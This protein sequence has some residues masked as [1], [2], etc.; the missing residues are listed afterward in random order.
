MKLT[1]AILFLLAF[2]A[3]LPAQSE[4]GGSVL[5]RLEAETAEL[6]AQA[7]AAVVSVGIWG[8]DSKRPLLR[9][10]PEFVSAHR[11]A[12]TIGATGV[13][14]GAPPRLVLPYDGTL[15]ARSLEFR[16]A[17]GAAGKG[18]LLDADE[19]LGV[20]VYEL[21]EATAEERVGLEVGGAS[22][23][24]RGRL[25]VLAGGPE[26]SRGALL[27]L[28]T[29]EG[30][31]R[32]GGF[33]YVDEG[34][35]GARAGAALVGTG[36]RLLGIQVADSAVALASRDPSCIRCH[37]PSVRPWF[38][39]GESLRL[40]GPQYD[41]SVDV[42]PKPAWTNALDGVWLSQYCPGWTGHPG[43]GARESGAFLA[44]PVLSRALSDIASHG[45]IRRSYLGVVLGAGVREGGV[46]VAA[47]LENS[48]A[49]KAGLEAGQIVGAVDGVPI[50][51]PG[52]LS[53]IIAL[54]PAGETLRL[55]VQPGSRE[56]DVTLADR[57]EA[58]LEL[59]TPDAVGLEAVDLG[60]EL[61][62]FL[63]LDDDVRGVVVRD[64]R[65]GSAAQQ[66]RM[67]RGDVIV[68]GDGRIADLEELRAALASAKGDI[69]LKVLRGGQELEIVLRYTPPV[70]GGGT[71]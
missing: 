70:P 67:L 55:L 68:G 38:D 33:V 11:A 4:P 42:D 39:W 61:R 64:V 17:D 13:L 52:A 31:D 40:K 16:F 54:R 7:D 12:G 3:L 60:E 1:L 53:R 35:R 19:E 58:R 56:L 23:L 37:T 47:V 66:A 41:T 20:A 57:A 65:A 28:V 30:V 26:V 62:T 45:R 32:H 69:A 27:R 5:A 48:P 9:A 24:G 2:C 8:G 43:I 22:D 51:D 25:A 71:R 34:G 10:G 59:V 49:A 44:A 36:G 29:V 6:A 18:K 50:A 15:K 63:G 14:V 46:R 21:D